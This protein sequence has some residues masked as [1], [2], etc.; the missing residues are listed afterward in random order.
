MNA[1]RRITQELR[2]YMNDT[3]RIE[4]FNKQEI[5]KRF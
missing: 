3:Q 2:E 5:Y 4:G 1:L